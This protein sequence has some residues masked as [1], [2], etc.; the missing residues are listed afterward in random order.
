MFVETNGS[1]AIIVNIDGLLSINGQRRYQIYSQGA[2]A[3]QNTE[4]RLEPEIVNSLRYLN[5]GHQVKVV[6]SYEFQV[7]TGIINVHL[8][9]LN[10]S[11]FPAQ[12]AL[13]Q[14][15]VRWQILRAMQDLGAR[16][17]ETICLCGDIDSLRQASSL[18]LGTIFWMPDVA[19]DDEAMRSLQKLGPDFVVQNSS[20]LQHIL[21]NRFLGNIAEVVACPG[22]FFDERVEN[23]YVT[24]IRCPN[25]EFP[26]FPIWV[27]GRYFRYEDPRWRK[28]PLSLRLLDSKRNLE[29]HKTT[30]ITIYGEL[31]TLVAPDGFDYVTRIP[32]R[33]GEPRDRLSEQIAMIPS[34][35]FKGTVIPREK[36]RPDL[37]RCT[38]NYP[39]QK[40]AGPYQV[41]RENVRGVFVAHTDVRGRTIVVVDDI[42]TSGSTLMEAT[43]VLVEAG[44]REV[45]PVAIA[46]HPENLDPSNENLSCPQC[47][48]ELAP[49]FNRI[50][51]SIFFG[52]RQWP[53]T[54]CRG[55]RNFITGVR[56]LNDQIRLPVVGPPPEVDL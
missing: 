2:R 11:V 17:C 23:R 35:T 22:G 38:S 41:R 45:I 36:I 8:P 40:E 34:Y 52:C 1:R 26:Q 15:I 55:S 7:I 10:R 30:L 50:D 48:A 31:I 12:T 49:R 6:T 28:H 37:L 19:L 25:S 42:T 44:A 13:E 54:G 32:S 4:V 29:T 27:G 3:D 33:P 43:R 16:P 56:E 39:S 20:M 14:R 21:E 53:H 5:A 51:A 18:R 47:G 9:E 24:A 46:Y